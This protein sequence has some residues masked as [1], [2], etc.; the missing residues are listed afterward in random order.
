MYDV[1]SLAVRGDRAQ[2]NF[3]VEQY[4][5]HYESL[6][7]FDIDSW[8]W[9]SNAK[10]VV[11]AVSRERMDPTAE[12][13]EASTLQ[14]WS[15]EDE[16]PA[17]LLD[18]ALKTAKEELA[19]SLPRQGLNAVEA[20]WEV[21]IPVQGTTLV[22]GVFKH[23][24]EAEVI[25]DLAVI[26]TQGF[27]G[28]KLHLAKSLYLQHMTSIAEINMAA[29]DWTDHLMPLARRIM[30]Q[31]PPAS[32]SAAITGFRAHRTVL[33]ARFTD[34][35]RFLTQA[36]SVVEAAE[37]RQRNL[38]QAE[39]ETAQRDKIAQI[40]ARMDGCSPGEKIELARQLH[41]RAAALKRMF[42]ARSEDEK[43]G[44][45][46]K[47]MRLFIDSEKKHIQAI[48]RTIQV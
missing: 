9:R 48:L 34:Y 7:K 36:A 20:G 21:A 8:Q 4:E 30:H 42:S 19:A 27:S 43:R 2:L 26:R 31:Q 47:K 45:M 15:D 46:V 11:M 39:E 23:K 17:A 40:V 13:Y 18:A 3:P 35:E 1:A 14:P 33:K 5:Q 16:D 6:R 25:H 44:I 41:D 28:P 22:V 24:P 38:R 32:L 29:A 10:R 12:D 37:D